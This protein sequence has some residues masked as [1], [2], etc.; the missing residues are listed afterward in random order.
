MSYLDRDFSTRS[1][2]ASNPGWVR[3]ELGDDGSP[4]GVAQVSGRRGSRTGPTADG[5][6]E[7]FAMDLQTFS[8][9]PVTTENVLSANNFH[10]YSHQIADVSRSQPDQD[11]YFFS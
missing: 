7:A 1:M 8:G 5:P 9:K 4:H 3:T 11:P 10:P 2:T 6:V